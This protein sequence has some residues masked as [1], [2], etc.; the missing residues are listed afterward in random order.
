MSVRLP[1]RLSSSSLVD[2]FGNLLH[3]GKVPA[4]YGEAK[5]SKRGGWQSGVG[6]RSVQQC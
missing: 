1:E 6:R 5:H 4:R 2:L 3:C